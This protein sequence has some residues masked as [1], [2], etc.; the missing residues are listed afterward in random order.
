MT[1]PWNG[2]AAWTGSDPWPGPD[3]SSGPLTLT[4]TPQPD[5]SPPRVRIDVDDSTGSL[6][7]VTLR[8]LD[9]DGRYRKVRTSD[10]GP[11]PLDAGSGTVYDFEAPF[12]Q[13]V[14]YSTDVAG[15][16]TVD[17]V[18][19]VGVPWLHHPQVPARSVPIAL[20]LG[21]NDEESWDIDQ[22]MFR[23]LEREDP[24]VF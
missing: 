19:D 3:S 8:R 18:L 1:Y 21:T 9:P 4:V 2:G 14:T 11:L 16:P 17:T 13:T 10:D 22:G 7:S 15:G 24:V 23:I 6:S 20:R 5:L 12:G